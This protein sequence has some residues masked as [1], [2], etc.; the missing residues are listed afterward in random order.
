MKRKI[1]KILLCLC[2][3]FWGLI[4]VVDPAFAH[5]SGCHRW[6]SCPSDSGSYTCGDAGHPC[7][8]PTYPA[9]GGVIY[10]PSGYY[11]DCYDCPLKKVPDNAYASGIGWSCGDGYE[12]IG[13]ACQKIIV[14]TPA[15]EYKTPASTQAN[16]QSAIQPVISIQDQIQS[17]VINEKSNY[18]KNPSWFRERLRD[19]LKKE[20]GDNYWIGFYVYTL[21]GD[22]K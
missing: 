19:T 20:F 14:P 17:R 22:V 16:I 13:D 11:K 10:P 18:Y 3:V 7:Q 6:H 8:Y 1:E 5:R 2:V 12:K 4:F 21:L 9:S 15:P